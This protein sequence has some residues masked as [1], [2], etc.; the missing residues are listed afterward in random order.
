MLKRLAEVAEQLGQKQVFS[1]LRSMQRGGQKK[2]SEKKAGEL[3]KFGQQLLSLKLE[4]EAFDTFGLILR[5]YPNNFQALTY[6]AA[7]LEQANMQ[8]DAL[9]FY[10]KALSIQ[11]HNS[12]LTSRL[13]KCLLAT[14]ALNEAM[15]IVEKALAK[16][17]VEPSFISLLSDILIAKGECD[18]ARLLLKELLA[19]DPG[20]IE[21]NFKLANLLLAQKS[22]QEVVRIFSS[23]NQIYPQNLMI[24]AHLSYALVLNEE[25]EQG[26]AQA[27]EVLRKDA[28]QPKAL[29]A[30]GLFHFSFRANFCIANKYFL[31]ALALTPNDIECLVNCG[32]MFQKLGAFDNALHYYEKVLKL[33]PNNREVK[34]NIAIIF[35]EQNNF[36]KHFELFEYRNKPQLINPDTPEW[37]GRSGLSGKDVLILHEQGLGDLFNECWYFHLLD[38]IGCR[39]T[40]QV[41]ERTLA[42]FENTFPGFDFISTQNRLVSEK[43]YDFYLSRSSL[44]LLY[45]PHFYSLFLLKSTQWNHS[46]VQWL[47]ATTASDKSNKDCLTIGVSWRSGMQTKGRGLEYFTAE[48]FAQFL[49]G[50][51]ATFVNLQY[52]ITEEETNVLKRVLGDKIQFP[53]IDLKDDQE[54]LAGIISGLDGVLAVCNAVL[55]LASALG[56]YGCW[57][58]PSTKTQ[59]CQGAF[60]PPHLI[61]TNKLLIDPKQP[62]TAA[63]ETGLTTFM[64]QKSAYKMVD[65]RV[66]AQ[67]LLHSGLEELLDNEI[68]NTHDLSGH[69]AWIQQIV[70]G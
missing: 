12:V 34:E 28:S 36:K 46:H 16:Q 68:Y 23:L 70:A 66:V 10:R 6:S 67:E 4:Q 62:E 32:F 45:W 17:P 8:Q 24:K 9:G 59:L 21:A 41:D 65:G 25:F 5:Y 51:D 43:K 30:M 49:N 33:E 13:A 20:E 57:T 48:C 15:L 37:D 31:K 64:R 44:G 39:A 26:R 53:E 1:V 29:L 60:L 54:A 63:Q 3:L 7:I 58:Q 27:L 40:I 69:R 42:L 47:K 19:R 2:L 14:G 50:L 35:R 61:N 22:Y 52:G 55:A 56:I 38:L 18:R 11:P